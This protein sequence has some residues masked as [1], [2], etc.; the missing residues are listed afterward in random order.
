MALRQDTVLAPW[1][2]DGESRPDRKE[3]AVV[4]RGGCAATKR[5][6]PEWRAHPHGKAVASEPLLENRIRELRSDRDWK[7]SRRRPLEGLR[8]LDL[9]RVLAGRDQISRGVRSGSVT[10]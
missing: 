8:V 6:I 7:A 9:T 1:Q 2:G 5:S 4:M 3:T 10:D